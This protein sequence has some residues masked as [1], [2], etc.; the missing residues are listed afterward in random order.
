VHEPA[1]ET[2][3]IW[4]ERPVSPCLMAKRGA[5]IRPKR[6]IGHVVE[7]GTRDYE[8]PK[9]VEDK[10]REGWTSHIP[11]HLLTDKA[12]EAAARGKQRK[13][14]VMDEETVTFRTLSDALDAD[15]EV[16]MTP[17]EF[18]QAYPRFLQCV[19]KFASDECSRWA[20]HH[21][22]L[23]ASKHMFGKKFSI[24]LRYDI[25]LRRRSTTSSFDPGTFQRG[26]WQDVND[27]YRFDRMEALMSSRNAPT[28][29]VATS[30]ASAAP[31][32]AAG[33]QSFRTSSS[34]AKTTPRGSDR[35]CILCGWRNHTWKHCRASKAY[36]GSPLYVTDP[37]DPRDSAGA[38]L[39]LNHNISSCQRT[40]PPCTYSHACSI[41][42]GK[43][44]AASVCSHAQPAGSS[45]SS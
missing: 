42:G 8:I 32:R 13:T 22:R 37:K 34:S 28:A 18:Q 5:A 25:E 14:Y 30:N 15:G 24:Y 41:C 33:S 12:V 19:S 11:L 23:C 29:S 21:Q 35:M 31:A 43:D 27:D 4:L 26:I 16:D 44:H 39:C 38:S 6:V 40:S 2:H 45:R 20:V 1:F 7:S 9:K 10:F 17:A 3:H 36:N